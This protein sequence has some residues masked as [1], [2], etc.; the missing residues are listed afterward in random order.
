MPRSNW[1]K[2]KGELLITVPISIPH[3]MFCMLLWL[4][5]QHGLHLNEE[6][7]L[8]LGESFDEDDIEKN[9][10]MGWVQ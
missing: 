6:I 5:E 10:H 2:R 8:R 4:A 3:D 1:N 9:P 7:L